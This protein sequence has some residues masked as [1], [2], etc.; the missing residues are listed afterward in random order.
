M[1]LQIILTFLLAY[2]IGSVPSAVWL[3]KFFYGKDVRNY[4]SG[5]AGATNTFRVL[6][7]PAGIIVLALDMLKGIMAVL[8]ANFPGGGNFS[9][10]QF[11]YYQIGLGLTAGLGHIFP[12]YLN[13]KG[14]KG[15]ATFFGVILYLFPLVALVC[16]ITFLTIFMITH[17]V[18]LSSM[19]ASVA[20]TISIFL[21]YLKDVGELPLVIFAVVVPVIIC[22]THRKNISR[23]LNGTESKMY[24][25]KKENQS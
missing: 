20:F 12:I 1:T 9:P 5:N 3:G 7:A 14:G 16:V 10:S 15:V 18:S 17:Y 23:I 21:L 2:L 25:F 24:F 8:L 13:F 19:I 11:L 4:G 6:G 22:Y